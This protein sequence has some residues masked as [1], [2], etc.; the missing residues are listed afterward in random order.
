M[1]EAFAGFKRSQNRSEGRAGI[2]HGLEAQG[3]VDRGVI[4]ACASRFTNDLAL[5]TGLRWLS[6]E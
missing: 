6:V 1:D 2:T 3:N 5:P 4:W